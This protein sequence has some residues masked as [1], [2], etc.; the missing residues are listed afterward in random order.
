MSEEKKL[1]KKLA[2]I[3]HEVKRIPKNGFNSF[4]KYN[5]ATESDVQDHV[6]DFL[7]E[8]HVMMISDV[9]EHDVREHTNRSNKI[10]YIN[11]VKLA[12]TFMDGETGETLTFHSVGE[13]QDSG[14]KGYYKAI[15]GAQKYA[16]MKAFMIPTGD[17]PEQDRKG[18]KPND[19]NQSKPPNKPPYKKPASQQQNQ[20]APPK[21]DDPAP[22][23]ATMQ[24]KNHITK[25]S[26]ELAQLRGK[27]VADVLAA[28]KI[29][30][31]EQVGYDHATLS[32][33]KVDEWIESA[34][35]QKE[36]QEA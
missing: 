2:A 10:E 31:V 22:R 19:S 4:N 17:D 28:L 12:V 11:M 1:I 14:D 3:M 5:Y 35:S 18:D 33:K 21:K 27:T 20:G 6:R 26:K 16:I 25:A 29:T 24:Q 32:V 7:A 30:D 34:K 23:V 9:V 13:G 36:K 15:T 8:R